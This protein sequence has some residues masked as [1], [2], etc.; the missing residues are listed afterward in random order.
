[1]AIL[2]VMSYYENRFASYYA[3]VLLPL[4]TYASI[5]GSL[6]TLEKYFVVSRVIKAN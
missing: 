2:F 3:D 6:K 4:R 5:W 1:M